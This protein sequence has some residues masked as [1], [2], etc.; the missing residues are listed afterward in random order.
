MIWACVML[1]GTGWQIQS[2]VGEMRVQGESKS[3]T[4]YVAEPNLAAPKP[5]PSPDESSQSRV[6]RLWTLHATEG[7]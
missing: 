6:A 7:L 4:E 2:W 1:V 5:I 3:Q